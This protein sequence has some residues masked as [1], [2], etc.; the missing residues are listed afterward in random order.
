MPDGFLFRHARLFS[1]PVMPDVSFPRHARPD[2]ASYLG[3]VTKVP[4]SG[5]RSLK[6]GGATS[7]FPMERV[8]APPKNRPRRPLSPPF[9]SPLLAIPTAKRHYPPIRFALRAHPTD[10]SGLSARLRSPRSRGHGRPRLS[11]ANA[12]WPTQA[13][14][15]TLSF[16]KHHPVIPRLLPVIPNSSFLPVPG[17]FPSFPTRSGIFFGGGDTKVPLSGRRS[18]KTRGANLLVRSGKNAM[19][20]TLNED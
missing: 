1:I 8:A 11:V 7:Q 2:R 15:T 14:R 3:G 17:F 19:Q 12:F 10:A 13:P 20:S 16:P 5:R 4:F 6:S 9:V 18:L